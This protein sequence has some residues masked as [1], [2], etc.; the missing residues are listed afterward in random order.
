MKKLIIL[1]KMSQYFSQ[2]GLQCRGEYA[3]M[4]KTYLLIDL[5]LKILKL[6]NMRKMLHEEFM[7]TLWNLCQA[8]SFIKN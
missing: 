6:L 4:Y 1:S 3:H 2:K 5:W 7:Y 8:S